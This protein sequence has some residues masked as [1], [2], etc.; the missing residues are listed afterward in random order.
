VLGLDT[1]A[2]TL[3]TAVDEGNRAIE[4]APGD[5]FAHA[6][7]AAA[8]TAADRLGPALQEARRA[9]D[10][11]PQRSD[12]L[13]A[14][15]VALRLRGEHQEALQAAQRAAAIEPDSPRVLTILA[16]ALRE[17]KRYAEAVEIYGQAIDLDHEAIAPQLGAAAALQ[18]KGDGAGARGLYNVLLKDWDYGHDR[19]L[20]GAAALLV[21]M[22]QYE[23][24]LDF[25]GRIELPDDATLPTLLAL[26]GKGYCLRK[27]NRD[28]EAE[29]F[30]S[31]LVARVPS[32]YDGPARGREM[33]FRAYGDLVDFFEARGR[34]RKVD[35]LLRSAAGR[36][37]APTRFARRLAARLLQRGNVDG[38][39]R[40]LEQALQRSDPEEDAIELAQT[41]LDLSRALSSAGRSRRLRDGTPAAAALARAAERIAAS[42]LGVAHYRLARAWA[43]AQRPDEAL[44]SLRRARDHGYLPV[45]T[46]AAETDFALLRDDAAFR[47][48]IG[49]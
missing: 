17:D 32:E 37:L 34:S 16:D 45:E 28:A 42:P 29:Y 43:L 49:H 47:E 3:Q 12:G 25:Y 11:D 1:R 26:Y 41:A 46:L 22:N 48:L 44:Q 10:L 30:L 4:L 36:P 6:A 14:L 18:L 20:L 39:E 23:S 27:L 7:L 8:L 2:S 38:A 15:S 21:A 35:S 13:L 40:L 31:T 24:A 9:V 5:A 19:A 33:L